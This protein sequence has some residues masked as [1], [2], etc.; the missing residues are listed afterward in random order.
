MREAPALAGREEREASP[1]RLA[2][3]CIGRRLDAALLLSGV[4]IR[5]CWSLPAEYAVAGSLCCATSEETVGWRV[6]CVD[7]LGEGL[8][9]PLHS[10]CCC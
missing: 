8:H 2:A 4:S 9:E 1:W 3:P 6:A 5:V 7:I 10:C